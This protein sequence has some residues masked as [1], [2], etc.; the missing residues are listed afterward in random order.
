VFNEPLPNSSKGI[1][2]QTHRLLWYDTEC[3][4]N[5]SVNELVT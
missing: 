3:I 4:E 1:H 5:F 2:G